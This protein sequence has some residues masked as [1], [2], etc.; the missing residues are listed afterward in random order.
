MVW[1]FDFGRVHSRHAFIHTCAILR[2]TW[3]NGSMVKS[4]SFVFRRPD[5]WSKLCPFTIFVILGS[6]SSCL[7][8]V[9]ANVPGGY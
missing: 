2:I 6:Y 9:I 5:F 1:Q 7:E 3:Q 4:W 8:L